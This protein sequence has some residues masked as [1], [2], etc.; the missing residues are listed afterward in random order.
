MLFPF[1]TSFRRYP[2]CFSLLQLL[3]SINI[4][5]DNGENTSLCAITASL[6]SKNSGVG[7][8]TT[9]VFFR[10]LFVLFMNQPLAFIIQSNNHPP[11]LILLLTPQLVHGFIP[12]LFINVCIIT[13]FC[14]VPHE[15]CQ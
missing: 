9:V 3:G 14:C 1:L 8:I 4:G 12:Y 7:Y 10:T 15:L 6:I 13:T 5:K 11:N 2:P